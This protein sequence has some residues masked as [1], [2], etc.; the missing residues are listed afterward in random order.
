[1][2]DDKQLNPEKLQVSKLATVP[3]EEKK[4]ES[5]ENIID[6]TTEVEDKEKKKELT[7]EEKKEIYIQELKKSVI[8]FH[9]IKHDGNITINTYNSKFKKKRKQKN[10]FTKI[11]RKANR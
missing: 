9:P 3:V 11:S 5:V 7:D 2:Q 8:K 6:K 4:T 1:M 10:K